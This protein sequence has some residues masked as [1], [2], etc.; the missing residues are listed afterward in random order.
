MNS[1]SLICGL[2]NP[3]TEYAET[4]HNAGFIVVDRFTAKWKPRPK[5]RT[6]CSGIV[7]EGRVR[8]RALI[9]LKPMT[10]MNKSGESVAALMRRRNLVPGELLLIYDDIDLP[11]GR[12]RIRSG[13]G[14]GGHNGVES[15]ATEVQSCDFARLRIGVGKNEEKQP[16]DHVLESFNDDERVIFDAVVVEAVKA[17][18]TILH[19]GV[20]AAMNQFNGLNL[21]KENNN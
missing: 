20:E 9:V 2:G 15:V 8:G 17:I 12:I 10:F 21:V 16:R 11:L 3:G 4:R 7:R 6:A 19:R 5:E 1:V 14:S 18:E 13:G